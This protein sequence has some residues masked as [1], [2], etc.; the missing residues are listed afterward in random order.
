MAAKKIKKRK[1]KAS[2]YTKLK[3]NVKGLKQLMKSTP[4]Q[5]KHLLKNSSKD[6]ISCISDVAYN[7]GRG[8]I[9]L[10]TCQYKSLKRGKK[11]IRILSD[12]KVGDKR[13]RTLL[14]KQKGSGFFLPLLAA[15]LPAITSL[16]GSR[17]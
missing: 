3:R 12:P 2:P 11:S 5:R 10:T 16:I 6:L 1:G 17:R 14:M 13:K 7:V 8:N 4:A 9:P 15:A